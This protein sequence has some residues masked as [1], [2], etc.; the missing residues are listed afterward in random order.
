MSETLESGGHDPSLSRFNTFM[1]SIGNMKVDKIYA[2]RKDRVYKKGSIYVK[3]TH[4][5]DFAFVQEEIDL[6][7][8]IQ[9]H[10]SPFLM[11]ILYNDYIKTPD[12]YY[13]VVATGRA[14]YMIPFKYYENKMNAN[15]VVLC[16]HDLFR[17]LM[18]LHQLGIAHRDIH[19]SNYVRDWVSG[20]FTL[21]DFDIACPID[22]H[23]DRGYL[24]HTGYKMEH[25]PCILLNTIEDFWE[26]TDY[27]YNIM[28]NRY[29]PRDIRPE[30][31]YHQLM[32]S[33]LTSFG[34]VSITQLPLV[35]PKFQFNL[36]NMTQIGPHFQEIMSFLLESITATELYFRTNTSFPSKFNRGKCETILDN[37]TKAIK[38]GVIKTDVT[39]W[40]ETPPELSSQF[41]VNNFTGELI[42]GKTAKLAKT[43]T[44]FF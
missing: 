19:V 33:I 16:F 13:M 7:R 4:Q 5:E 21:I 36:D 44:L 9:A 12:N 11:R 43:H 40:S 42:L 35:D 34:L 2:K 29:N 41:D 1:N 26:G 17:G 27:I 32:L 18:A 39:L 30:M 3:L 20:R 38:D 28:R 25:H 15:D 31:D 14:G 23:G 37:L 6:L 8:N 24:L 10:S 22:D